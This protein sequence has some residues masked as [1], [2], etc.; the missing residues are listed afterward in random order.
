[1]TV[2]NKTQPMREAEIDIADYINGTLTDKL[3]ELDATDV[4]LQKNIDTETEQRIDG[5]TEL[6][7]K[8]TT[9]TNERI[10][11]DN[12]LQANIDAEAKTRETNDTTLQANIDAEAGRAKAEEAKLINDVSNNL[13]KITA[14]EN[15]F[16]VQTDYI[17]D[18]SVTEEKL[19]ESLQTLISFCKTLPDLEF[20][21]S[22]AISLAAGGFESFTV[23]F[24]TAK[25]EAPAV[26]VSAQCNSDS[27]ITAKVKYTTTDSVVIDV[28]NNGTTTAGNI[29]VDWLAISGR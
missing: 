2:I 20:G 6:T 7:N 13:T 27:N 11:A 25:T 9:E 24:A 8:L 19:S 15:L 23:T 18:K 14:L 29:T 5:D 28:Y 21:Y 3:A 12:T 1:M 17:Y 26:L 16:P 10:A 22:D 4:Q